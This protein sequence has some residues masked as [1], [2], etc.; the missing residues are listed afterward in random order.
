MVLSSNVIE[1]FL[2]KFGRTGKEITYYAWNCVVHFLIFFVYYTGIFDI[3]NIRVLNQKAY[4]NKAF[5]PFRDPR[6]SQS[7][8]VACRNI[9]K[10]NDSLPTK[11]PK[12]WFPPS[13]REQ[14]VHTYY[15]NFK[16][17]HI[18]VS[19]WRS[20][21][22]NYRNAK[23]NEENFIKFISLFFFLFNLN[24]KLETHAHTQ[25]KRKCVFW[26]L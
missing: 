2:I 24:M 8:L 25:K 22:S 15:S 19:R 10:A 13:K 21:V 16:I 12:I 3:K 14:V 20:T 6:W 17:V 5:K 7:I 4:K 11:F 9:W 26:N 1:P 23:F 18:F